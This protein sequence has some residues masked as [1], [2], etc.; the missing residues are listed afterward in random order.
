MAT[1]VYSVRSGGE[2]GQ[3]GCLIKGDQVT[4]SSGKNVIVI[5]SEITEL[6]PPDTATDLE[7]WFSTQDAAINS[8]KSNLFLKISRM[9]KVSG[10]DPADGPNG[11]CVCGEIVALQRFGHL[12]RNSKGCNGIHLNALFR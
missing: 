5:D 2:L 10:I 6:F 7:N 1:R 4:L 12:Q 9:A 11:R 3:C 8:F